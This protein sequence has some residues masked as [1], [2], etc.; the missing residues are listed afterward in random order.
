M[1]KN[2]HPDIVKEFRKLENYSLRVG[3]FYSYNPQQHIINMAHEYGLD[4]NMS[5]DQRRYMAA[6]FYD[7]MS[8]PGSGRIRFPERGTLRNT[9][10]AKNAEWS[11]MFKEHVGG[12][13]IEERQDAYELLRQLGAH[14]A[15]DLRGVI[16]ET[17][18]VKSG[19]MLDSMQYKV[20]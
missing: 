5:P 8:S 20:D 7:H 14:F 10:D 11:R 9:F 15:S 19:G 2:H 6:N 17:F 4:I 3:S 1:P 18:A 12:G 16:Q 13:I